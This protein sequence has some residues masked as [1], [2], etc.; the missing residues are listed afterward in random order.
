MI[1]YCN[2]KGYRFYTLVNCIN[3]YFGYAVMR[4]VYHRDQLVDLC[5]I[6]FI[7][8]ILSM[9]LDVIMSSYLPMTPFFSRMIEM[10]MLLKKKQV[11]CLKKIR[12][13]LASQ[14]SINSEKTNF[15]LFH[16]KNKLI[17]ENFDCIPT[18]F[19]TIYR[20]KYVQYLGPMI[21]ENL[22]WHMHVKHVYNYLLK[23]FRIFNHIKLSYLKRLQRSFILLLYICV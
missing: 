5:R 2:K 21:D 12:W 1:E 18:T 17:P 11:I 3:S 13:C 22:T 10:L 16:V 9:Q 15:V 23:Y 20:V 4:I 8:M 6:Y 7:L 14:L 19:L